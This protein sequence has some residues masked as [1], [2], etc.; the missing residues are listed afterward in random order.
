MSAIE[1]GLY[2]PT[3]KCV[4]SHLKMRATAQEQDIAQNF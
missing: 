3:L 2:T 1:D 4:F